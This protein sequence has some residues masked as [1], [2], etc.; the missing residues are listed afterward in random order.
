MVAVWI[1][2]FGSLGTHDLEDLSIHF[3]AIKNILTYIQ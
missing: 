2:L 3:A 1:M